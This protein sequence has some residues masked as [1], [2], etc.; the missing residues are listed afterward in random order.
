MI[1]FSLVLI[2]MGLLTNDKPNLKQATDGCT[3]IPNVAGDELGL[4]N[5]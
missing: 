2:E 5:K 3:G 1:Y 4:P